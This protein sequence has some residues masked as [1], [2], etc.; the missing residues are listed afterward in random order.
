MP[1]LLCDCQSFI[2][3]SYLLTLARNGAQNFRPLNRLSSLT[4]L[5]CDL[6]VLVLVDVSSVK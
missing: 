4:W 2:K 5:F 3:E 1:M 6:V